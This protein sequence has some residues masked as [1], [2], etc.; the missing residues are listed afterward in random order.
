MEPKLKLTV[1]ILKTNRWAQ[2]SPA[3]PHDVYVAGEIIK[4]GDRNL[5]QGRIDT[6]VE[7]GKA[8]IMSDREQAADKHAKEEKKAEG[9]G[10]T[11]RGKKKD[12]KNS[13]QDDLL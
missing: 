10:D 12:R 6:M 3:E 13:N 8:K 5:T 11:R 9:S 7:N 4:A 2:D 1:K